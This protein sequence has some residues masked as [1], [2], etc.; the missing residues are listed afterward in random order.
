MNRLTPKQEKWMRDGARDPQWMDH[1]Q[2]C[3]CNACCIPKLLVELDAVRA[4]LK[5]SKQHV[6]T[7]FDDCAQHGT[8]INELTE[9]NARLRALP[10]LTDDLAEARENADD[11]YRSLIGCRERLSR[12]IA[13]L[14][15]NCSQP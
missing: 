8:H 10:D 14:T 9:E 1:S 15:S 3:L 13:A 7:L 11:Y 5:E 4:E 6:E 2:K 12:A